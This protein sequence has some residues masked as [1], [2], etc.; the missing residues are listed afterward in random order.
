MNVVKGASGG[1]CEVLFP[2]GE[3]FLSIATSHAVR[4]VAHMMTGFGQDCIR[5]DRA[6]ESAVW[7][8]CPDR[9]DSDEAGR[10]HEGG[11][12]RSR[13]SGRSE[14]TT[15]AP[16]KAPVAC[17][18]ENIQEKLRARGVGAQIKRIGNMLG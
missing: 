3:A 5:A 11:S 14:A 12:R 6:L 10:G 18:W 4:L 15:A 8:T 16:M 2:L 9:S 1:V 7:A 17:A 13:G